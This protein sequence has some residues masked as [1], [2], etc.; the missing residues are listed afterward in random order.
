MRDENINQVAFAAV[1]KERDKARSQI[2]MMVKHDTQRLDSDSLVASCDC[3]TKSPEV[4]YHKVG[5]KYR[6]IRER[7][8]AREAVNTLNQ[9]LTERTADMLEKIVEVERTTDQATASK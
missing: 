5:C 3:L 1:C 7:D 6:L 2:E 4:M 8:E 9:R